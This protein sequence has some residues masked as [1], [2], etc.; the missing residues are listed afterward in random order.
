M[1]SYHLYVTYSV[2]FSFSAQLFGPRTGFGAVMR[3]DLCVDFGA[4]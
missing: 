1:V 3:Y 4:V 2:A